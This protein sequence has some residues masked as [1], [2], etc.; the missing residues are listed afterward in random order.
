M[1]GA[2]DVVIAAGVENM[3]RVPMGASVA[4]GPGMGFGPTMIKRYESAG[5]L[6]PQGISAELICDK[7]GITREDMDRLRRAVAPACRPGHR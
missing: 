3:S 4:N 2:Y 7:W 6:V 5:G 1:S